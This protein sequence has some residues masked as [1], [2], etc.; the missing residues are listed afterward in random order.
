MNTSFQS[1]NDY[2]DKPAV[3][4]RLPSVAVEVYSTIKEDLLSS[5]G[6]SLFS[7]ALRKIMQRN[8]FPV[9]LAY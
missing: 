3:Q 9:L 5:K 8:K 7:H 1:H 2:L 6:V 4:L